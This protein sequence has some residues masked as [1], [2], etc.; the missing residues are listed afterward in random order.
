MTPRQ[1]SAKPLLAAFAAGVLVTVL[2]PARAE[3]PVAK[4]VN[5]RV[6]P[7]GIPPRKLG[8]IMKSWER[9]LGVR[10][11]HCH[12]E[13]RDTGKVDYVSDENPLKE[14]S[15]VM[16]AMLQAINDEYLGSLGGDRRYAVPVT[17]GSCHQGR[18][19][20]PSFEARR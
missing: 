18:A 1:H 12:V 2:S 4:P 7:S 6:L 19:S 13:D 9:D 10:C 11:A 3:S 20:P 5:L 16:I 15:R 8:Q 17:C 14:V